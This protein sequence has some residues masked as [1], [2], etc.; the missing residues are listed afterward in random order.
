MFLSLNLA[1]AMPL[2]YGAMFRLLRTQ[3]RVFTGGC[4]GEQA[5]LEFDLTFSDVWHMRAQS[6]T[7]FII[8]KISNFKKSQRFSPHLKKVTLQVLK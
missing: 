6:Q 8:A 7:I 4:M 2:A 3:V 5:S 1:G